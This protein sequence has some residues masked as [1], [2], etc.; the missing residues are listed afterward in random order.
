MANTALM[1]RQIIGTFLGLLN[2]GRYT[3]HASR[4]MI[5][6]T[7]TRCELYACLFLSLF[8]RGLIFPVYR[9]TN[10]LAAIAFGANGSSS[11]D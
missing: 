3:R 6:Q 4:L 10:L 9:T 5:D 7:G 11:D 1:R 2:D 8:R